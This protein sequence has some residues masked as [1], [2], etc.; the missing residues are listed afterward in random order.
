MSSEIAAARSSDEATFVALVERYRAQ[1][2]L[3][4]YR[5]VGSVE[6]SE[7]LVQ[8]TV[9]RAWRKRASYQGRSALRT[10]LYS[11][12]TNAC[13]DFLARRPPRELTPQ[14]A[15]A[16]EPG[17]AAPPASELVWLDPYPEHLLAGVASEDGDPEAAL[18]SKETVELAFLA[19]IQHL[20]PIGRAALILRDVLG[21]SAKETAD[22]LGLTVP[23]VNS[24]LQRARSTLRE[25][26]PRRRVEWSPAAEPSRD[27]LLL[28]RRYTE[29][30][31]RGDV[32][33]LAKLLR[34][35]VRLSAPPLPGA[36]EGRDAVLA[37]IR[38]SAA[39]G[40]FR[41]VVT[42]ANHQPA[43]ASYVRRDGDSAYRPLAIDVLRV[44]RGLLARID[45]FLRPDL[46]PVF[47]LPPAL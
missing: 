31:E 41:Y 8:E 38:R 4:C 10:W 2:Q 27:E 40:R 6:D 33:S 37:S 16:I 22:G 24:A 42:R 5:M 44:E 19:A 32:A 17:A 23:S 15:V 36:R 14:V 12:A 39:P 13:L 34:A 30:H 47:G 26:L 28:L 11:I 7:D 1:L 45:V 35:D 9:L 3:H 21:C 46:F 20:T 29:A 43:A 18:A 25:H